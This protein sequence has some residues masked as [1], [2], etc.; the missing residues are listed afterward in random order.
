MRSRALL[1]QSASLGV[2]F[3]YLIAAGFYPAGLLEPRPHGLTISR[4][5]P[6]DWLQGFPLQWG[7]KQRS[8]PFDLAERQS[9]VQLRRVGAKNDFDVRHGLAVAL[10]FDPLGRQAQE[11]G[12]E[13]RCVGLAGVVDDD[14]LSSR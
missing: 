13:A 14:G 4:Q 7:C 3:L 6:R 10:H 2:A 12:C 11:A 5:L 1:R 8:S 9:L